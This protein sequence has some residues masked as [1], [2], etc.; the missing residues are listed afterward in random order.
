MKKIVIVIAIIVGVIMLAFSFTDLKYVFQVFTISSAGN[1]PTLKVGS[2]AIGTN[3]KTPK[4]FDLI[5]YEQ[6]L[7]GFPEG[8]WV[9]RLCGIEKDTIEIRKGILYVNGINVDKDLTLNHNYIT[10]NSTVQKLIEMNVVERGEITI[11]N[12]DS[13]L[14]VLPDKVA[15]TYPNNIK[16][17]FVKKRDED[18]QAI[19]GEAW[20]QDDFGPLV[21]PEKSIFVL[22]DNRNHSYDSR[23][24]GFVKV[25]KIKGV[26]LK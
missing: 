11:V 13:V 23:F 6:K 5:L 7:E 25:E 24:F 9:Q 8:I 19:Y 26:L 17:F 21:V 22:G 1:E 4:K 3:L 10:D 2:F 18:I 14:V 16:R 15:F 12:K 20:S